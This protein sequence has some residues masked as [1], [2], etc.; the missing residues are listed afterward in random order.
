MARPRSLTHDRIAAAALAVVDRD[1]LPTLSMRTVATE[2]GIGT[3][4]LYRYVADREEVERLIVDSI[5]AGLDLTLPSEGLWTDLVS[6]LVQ[7]MRTAIGDHPHVT[8]LLVAHRH[9]STGLFRWGEAVLAVLTSA[10]FVGERRV[11]AFRCLVSYVIGT[12]QYQQLGSVSGPG[13]DALAA[14]RRDEYPLLGQAARDARQITS[15]EEFRGGLA[16]VLAGI[17][18]A[19]V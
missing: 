12:L 5:L 1:G 10:G 3:M 9:T 17:S 8:P 16:L 15:D 6:L 11:I 2:L 4:S 14:L 18:R 13:T 19:P 7:R